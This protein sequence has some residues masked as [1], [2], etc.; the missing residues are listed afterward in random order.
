V[1]P[2]T[3]PR[4]QDETGPK[5]VTMLIQSSGSGIPAGLREQLARELEE[6]D[7]EE[8]PSESDSGLRL[9]LS[10]RL[11]RLLGGDLHLDQG[12]LAGPTFHLYFRFLAGDKEKA[13]QADQPPLL[14]GYSGKEQLTI[15]LAEDQEANAFLMQR[16]IERLGHRMLLAK[17]GAEALETLKQTACDLVLMDI[18]MPGMDGF[19][20]TRRIRQGEAGAQAQHL[21]IV[22]VTAHAFP[23]YE[24]KAR[25]AGMDGFLTKP[26]DVKALQDL[27]AK[28]LPERSAEMDNLQQDSGKESLARELLQQGL[29]CHQQGPAAPPVVDRLALLQRMAGDEE[30][31]NQLLWLFQQNTPGLLQEM[32]EALEQKDC[33]RLKVQAHT[34]KGEASNVDAQYCKE[35]AQELEKAAQQCDMAAAQQLLHKTNEEAARAMEHIRILMKEPGPPAF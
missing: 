6:T 1:L 23:E 34:L 19:E 16:I 15:V 20:A 25:E 13:L 28:M 27:F 18:E 26:I 3:A 7:E 4:D 8:R 22:A 21:P 29:D 5:M 14:T 30:L 35:A 17:N 32:R 9:T 11:A 10:R 33:D 2:A 12:F 31:V 24:T